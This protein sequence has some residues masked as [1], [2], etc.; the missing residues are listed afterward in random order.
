M[1]IYRAIYIIQ[2]F[3][4]HSWW[5]TLY[6]AQHYNVRAIRDLRKHHNYNAY[7]PT[8][9]R[10]DFV[11]RTLAVIDSTPNLYYN[12]Y[13]TIKA[14]FGYTRYSIMN[15]RCLGFKTWTFYNDH[16]HG[17]V[18]CPTGLLLSHARKATML[19]TYTEQVDGNRCAW[20]LLLVGIGLLSQV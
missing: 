13:Y 3:N 18:S 6:T 11:P 10:G 12:Y 4:E 7:Q 2:N 19:W 9:T 14:L 1:C 20:R 5:I 15:V 8:A 17:S 16:R